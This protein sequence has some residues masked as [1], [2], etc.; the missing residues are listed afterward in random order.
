MAKIDFSNL[1]MCSD[2]NTAFN[3]FRKMYSWLNQGPPSRETASGRWKAYTLSYKWGSNQEYA[4]KMRIYITQIVSNEVIKFTKY[5]FTPKKGL[6]EPSKEYCPHHYI[7]I[8]GVG[9]V[10]DNRSEWKN[11]KRVP[12]ELL[13]YF[14]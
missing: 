3:E 7:F 11:D 9:I 4:S 8:K 2:P 14:S 6:Y 10:P 5:S 12:K 13:G 1:I